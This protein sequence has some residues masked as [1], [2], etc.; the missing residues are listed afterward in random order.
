MVDKKHGNQE[1][2]SVD[3]EDMSVVHDCRGYLVAATAEVEV[4]HH[5]LVKLQWQPQA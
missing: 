1:G 5:L 3:T 4:Q 2:A